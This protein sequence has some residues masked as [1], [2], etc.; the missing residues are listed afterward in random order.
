MARFRQRPV[1]VDAVQIQNRVM[2]ETLA[3]ILT[4]EPVPWLTTGVSGEYRLYSDDVF[5]ASHEPVT[6]EA[7]DMLQED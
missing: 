2:I 5:R 3:G 4:G 7:Q 1:L 6:V